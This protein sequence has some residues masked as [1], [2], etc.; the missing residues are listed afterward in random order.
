M[1]RTA[2][3]PKTTR[4]KR[5]ISKMNCLR[6]RLR[7]ASE[8]LPDLDGGMPSSTVPCRRKINRTPVRNRSMSTTAMPMASGGFDQ[9]TELI[10][11][12]I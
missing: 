12:G 11:L 9:M 6:L 8:F 3:M 10:N 4:K 1:L 7:S 2:A 5:S